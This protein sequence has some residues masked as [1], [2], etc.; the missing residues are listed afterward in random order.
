MSIRSGMADLSAGS[1]RHLGDSGVFWSDMIGSSIK[2]AYD[3]HIT[4]ANVYI[5]N[6]KCALVYFSSALHKLPVAVVQIWQ[7]EL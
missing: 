1:L 4:G 2:G 5:F 7:W 3:I 6:Q